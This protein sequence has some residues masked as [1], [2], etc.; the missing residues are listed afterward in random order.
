MD[1]PPREHGAHPANGAPHRGRAPPANANALDAIDD[2]VEF[3]FL[4]DVAAELPMQVICILLG[5]PEADRHGLFEAVEHI[6]DFRGDAG[7]V[8]DD[9][10]R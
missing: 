8:R 4:V 9:G 1:P 6:F 7:V 3:D 2:G 5:V 10:R